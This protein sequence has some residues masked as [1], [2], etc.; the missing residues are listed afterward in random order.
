MWEATVTIVFPLKSSEP[1]EH[2]SQPEGTHVQDLIAN[3]ECQFEKDFL[4]DD[5]PVPSS[6]RPVD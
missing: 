4:S 5:V 2:I 1:S 3:Y 6:H